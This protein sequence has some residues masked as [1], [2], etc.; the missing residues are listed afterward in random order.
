M[1]R[2]GDYLD[3]AVTPAVLGTTSHKSSKVC[4]RVSTF[5]LVERKQNI[6]SLFYIGVN[7]GGTHANTH[8]LVD[9]LN[10]IYQWQ[11]SHNRGFDEFL[12][13]F[14]MYQGFTVFM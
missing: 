11:K 13:L 9:E 8:R 12:F 3:G 6:A 14:F 5:S 4:S 2:D 7:G 10:R 1:C